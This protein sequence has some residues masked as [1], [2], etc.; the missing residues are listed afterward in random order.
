MS[1]LFYESGKAM[2]V[3]PL[4]DLC[5]RMLVIDQATGLNELTDNALTIAWERDDQCPVPYADLFAP[6]PRFNVEECAPSGDAEPAYGS[7]DFDRIEDSQQREAARSKALERDF[8]YRFY[9]QDFLDWENAG[10]TYRW[11]FVKTDSTVYVAS[12][13]PFFGWRGDR[14]QQFRPSNRLQELIDTA[15]D[16]FTDKMIG[17]YA[18][19]DAVS[20][21]ALSDLL[22]ILKEE[23]GQM[24]LVVSDDANVVDQITSDHLSTTKLP[25]VQNLSATERQL[26]D[27]NCLSRTGHVLASTDNLFARTA[28]LMNGLKF[29][30]LDLS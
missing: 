16:S 4:G 14:A 21:A 5:T 1:S 29:N 19:S 15:T 23:T 27:L 20:V 11:N 6:S 18:K 7:V 13:L 9:D 17:V 10:F 30:A 8:D 26:I 22:R 3:K 12:S 25:G 28:A 24:P 2:V